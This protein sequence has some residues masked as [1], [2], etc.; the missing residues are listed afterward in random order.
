MVKGVEAWTARVCLAG[1][2]LAVLAVTGEAAEFAPAA[3]AQ[4]RVTLD[5]HAVEI[6]RP[7]QIIAGVSGLNM[8]VGR[9]VRGRVTVY[10]KDVPWKQALESILRANGYGYVRQGNLIRI[11]KLDVLR[12]ERESRLP[13]GEC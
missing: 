7:L 12:K 11:D 10:L 8:V 13:G 3:K 5:F 9:E 6:D 1:L 2:L 4:N